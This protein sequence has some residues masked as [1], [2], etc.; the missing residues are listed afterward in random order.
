MLQFN[1]AA[2]TSKAIDSWELDGFA[3]DIFH[4]PETQPPIFHFILT[5]VNNAEILYW[6]QERSLERAREAARSLL[7]A[8]AVTAGTG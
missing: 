2:A 7:T 1:R 8:M 6:G 5:Q 4:N 3:A